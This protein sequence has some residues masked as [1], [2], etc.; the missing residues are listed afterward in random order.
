MTRY[1]KKEFATLLSTY[2]VAASVDKQIFNE[3]ADGKITLKECFR[4]WKHNNDIE[5]W[6]IEA[7][8][9]SLFDFEDWLYSLGYK[10]NG[11]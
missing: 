4:E 7:Y 6:E 9:L 5:D 2:E 10:G 11:Y 8:N 1:Y 3:W